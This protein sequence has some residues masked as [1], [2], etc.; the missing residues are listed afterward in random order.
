ML[1]H[2][3]DGRLDAPQPHS[4][5]NG[6]ISSQNN[7]FHPHFTPPAPVTVHY[8]YD[9][10]ATMNNDFQYYLPEDQLAYDVQELLK[11]L[12]YS[13]PLNLTPNSLG[14]KV[15]TYSQDISMFSPHPTPNDL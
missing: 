14:I 6:L 11:Q 5:F 3:S 4:N 12:E 2:L 10:N 15:E 8:P 7:C 1:Y 9:C 13:V